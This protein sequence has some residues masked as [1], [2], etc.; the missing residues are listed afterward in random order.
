MQEAFEVIGGAVP[1]NIVLDAS[2]FDMQE[3]LEVLRE[4]VK[5]NRIEYQFPGGLNQID[6]LEECRALNNLKDFDLMYDITMQMLEGKPLL[7]LIKNYDSSKTVLASFQITDRYMD[8]RGQEAISK[9][10]YLVNWLTEFMGAY[11][12]KKFPVPMRSQPQ[13]QAPE[14]KSGKKKQAKARRTL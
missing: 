8:L 11:L 5:Q 6:I 9:Y 3:T 10:P 1:P 12:A 2:I 14:K 7:I 13:A 4:D